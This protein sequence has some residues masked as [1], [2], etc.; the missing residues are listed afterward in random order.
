MSEESTLKVNPVSK[1]YRPQSGGN[2]TLR[3]LKVY[4]M[5]GSLTMH[6]L[7]LSHR[8]FCVF[9]DISRRL[10]NNQCRTWKTI[11]HQNHTVN[12]VKLISFMWTFLISMPGLLQ[13]KKI[14]IRVSQQSSDH[15]F[16]FKFTCSDVCS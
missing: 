12:C 9:A 1:L 4:L 10:R 3:L 6:P 15:S 7:F 16:F 5:S 11:A 8:I 13:K 2:P 14:K